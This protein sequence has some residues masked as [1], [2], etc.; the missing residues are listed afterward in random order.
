MFLWRGY[1]P[2]VIGIVFACSLAANLLANFIGGPTYWNTHGW[3]IAA[4]FGVDAV[5][6]WFL[7]LSLAK[8][9]PRTL[10]DE[11]TGERFNLY[12]RHDLFFL[13]I[14][15]WALIFAGLAVLILLTRWSPG[16]G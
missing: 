1:G 2:V 4:S 13:R 8:K 7:D 9:R 6:V 10:V 16:P 11:A 12:R 14:R 5:I 3:P 15:W